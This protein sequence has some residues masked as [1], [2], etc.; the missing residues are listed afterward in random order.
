MGDAALTLRRHLETV[1]EVSS[2]VNSSLDTEEVRVRSILA[3]TGLL[4]AEA[5]SLILRDGETGDLSIDVSVGDGSDRVRHLKL[6]RGQGIAGWVAE[7][8]MPAIVNDVRKDLRF[9]GDVDELSGFVTTSLICVPVKSKGAVVGVL[10]ALNKK[11]GPFLAEDLEVLEVLANQVAVALENARLYEEV[12]QMFGAVIE[13]LLETVEKR[14]AYTRG[15]TRRVTGHSVAI[16][17][18]LGLAK[19]EVEELRLAAMLHDIGKI[20]ISDRVLHKDGALTHEELETVRHHPVYGAE[21]L[22]HIKKLHGVLPGVKH[23][24][25]RYN[26]TGYPGGLK[27]SDIPV[28]ARIIAVADT[29]DAMVTDRPYRKGLAVYAAV[30]E[31]KKQRGVQFD[32]AVVAAFLEGYRILSRDL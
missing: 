30:E 3:T 18:G 4:G 25:E 11:S 19:A 8:G 16:G 13:A 31:L 10:E 20:G 26:G 28:M 9:C 15:H 27:G 12:G 1:M 32:P 17:Q 21:I 7:R 6:R 2:L 23:H 29:F 24:H 22:Q 5:G 14:D